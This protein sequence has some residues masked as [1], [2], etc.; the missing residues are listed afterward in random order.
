[1]EEDMRLVDRVAIVTGAT[2]GIGR[3]IAR[4]FAQEGADIV[5]VYLRSPLANELVQEVQTLGRRAIAVKADISNFSEVNQM[6]QQAVAE[7]GKVDI[8]VNNAGTSSVRALLPEMTEE[9][10]DRVINTNLK[11]CFLCTLL[12]ARQMIKQRRGGKIINISSIAADTTYAGQLAYVA[13]KGGVN[14]LTRAAAID[15]APYH[16]NVNAIAPGS[17]DTPM[18][19]TE[20]EALEKRKAKI[21]LGKLAKPE[22]I[23]A[24]AVFLASEDSDHLTGSIIVVDGAEVINRTYD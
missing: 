3:A 14:S 20:K 6:V 13:S 21:P 8:L 17:T 12:A 24:T 16:I 7:F 19:R 10:W 15:L 4:R 23:A 5:I 2:G 22:D 11:G 9:D 1:M 18:L